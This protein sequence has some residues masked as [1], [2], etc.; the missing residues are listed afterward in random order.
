MQDAKS[1]NLVKPKVTKLYPKS[2]IICLIFF[3]LIFFELYSHGSY[4]EEILG[5][6]SIVLILLSVKRL[7]S[8]DIFTVSLMGLVII[9]G[10]LANYLYELGYSVFS[11]LVDVLTQI[12]LPMVF[13]AIRY[14]LTEKEKRE[15]INMLVPIAKL[16]IISA[17]L[18]AVISQFVDIGMTSGKRYGLPQFSFIFYFNHTYTSV[19]F[20]FFGVIVCTD[21]ISQKLKR[22]Y[23]IIGIVAILASLKSPAL[24]FSVTFVFLSL[25]LK[26]YQKVSLKIVIPLIVVLI[27]IS[28]YQLD[29]YLLNTNAPR[30]LF[31]DYAI[32][33][34][35]DYFPL[36]SGFGTYGSAEAAKHYSSL[37]YTYGF[38]KVWGMSPAYGPFLADTYWP[39]IL[40]QFG[41]FG[42]AFYIIA[43]IQIF[44]TLKNS[45]AN[46][47]RKALLYG[48][49]IQYMVHALGAAILSNS[50]GM[51]GFMAMALF[52]I[53]DFE[54]DKQKRNRRFKIKLR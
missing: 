34:A 6:I 18:C 11:V 16:F 39:T 4:M 35:N 1:N 9:I 52:A 40:A 50:A 22:F 10:L 25:Y 8:R 44:I 38:D 20:L 27:Y 14:S 32:R 47:E 28:G 17:F 49:F 24:V 43:Y 42:F 29:T 30:R 12:K 31:I 51:I 36:G 2:L 33:T 41:W 45:K 21:K 46:N 13:Y 26:R 5:I 23:Y 37:Y 3:G 48:I 19:I 15:A 54:K 53:P 7:T